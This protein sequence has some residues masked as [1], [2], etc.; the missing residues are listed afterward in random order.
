MA[1]KAPHIGGVRRTEDRSAL[2]SGWT[3]TARWRSVVVLVL[4]TALLARILLSLH[5]IARPG[6][7]SDETLFVNAA[8]LQAPVPGNPGH[9][10]LGI[11]INIISYVGGL[12]SWIY[13]PIFSVFGTSA[14][15]VRIPVVLIVSGSLL[16]VYL[17]V[18]DLVNRPVALLAVVLLAFDQSVFWFTRNDVGPSALE[19][20]LKCA[21]LFC[22]ARY[23]ER[24]TLRWIVLLLVV[25]GAGLFNKLNFIWFV[26]A[27]VL[28][29]VVV[30]IRHRTSLRAARQTLFVWF[31]ALAVVY[32]GFGAVYLHY[33]LGGI[34][35]GAAEV[36]SFT[37]RWSQFVHGSAGIL[38]GTS[39]F[40]YALGPIGP[41]E[42]V[43]AMML[44][45]FMIGAV[46]SVVRWRGRSP[47]VAGI[48]VATLLIALQC[49][50][51]YAAVDGW[52]YIAI[53][54][55]VTIVAAYGAWV[56]AAALF[57][58]PVRIAT[59]L[60]LVGL[61]A[62]VYDGLLFAKYSRALH[63]E[64]RS[65]A[66]TPGIYALGGYLEHQ[67]GTVFATDFG[68]VN[69]LLTVAPSTRYQ[70]VFAAWNQTRTP[71]L[72]IR[73]EIANTP[74]HKLFVTRAPGEVIFNKARTN[75]L[76][77]AGSRLLLIKTIDGLKGHPAFDVYRWR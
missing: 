8:T 45:L 14:A 75:L 21:A 48:A 35:H 76:T 25:L 58:S 15:T 50:L 68:I 49:L 72:L 23:W 17:A 29:S 33:G 19:F 12:K 40:G 34:T 53:Y 56:I 52:H 46:A 63:D 18:R 11:P 20:A 66:W 24:R 64:P 51:T 1:L 10:L 67:P 38:S 62:L 41:R 16:L 43:G 37:A 69:P 74:G 61:T 47:A 59:A 27:V 13:A 22:V 6:L 55:F 39:F 28:I 4:G 73:N 9:Y 5:M 42:L 70:D 60:A 65:S 32:A 2:I 7:D 44:A 31:G 36:N 30:V 57:R 26:N 54:P 3:T 71:A 77:A